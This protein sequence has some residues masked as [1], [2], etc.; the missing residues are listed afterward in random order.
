MR[1]LVLLG[2]ALVTF[3][4]PVFGQPKYGVT[5]TA[6]K[7]TDFTKF[8][9]YVWRTG[10]DA[11][12]KVHQQIVAAVDR[13]MKA[14]GYEKKAAGPSDVIVQYAAVRRIDVDVN[15]KA[16]GTDAARGQTDVGTLDIR[17]LKPGS[18]DQLWRARIDK[19]LETTDPAKVGEI[20]DG[21]VKELFA[22]YPTRMMKGK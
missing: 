14:L 22:Q 8:K 21:A 1:R 10:W 9:T 7:S 11:S 16:T 17:L 4:L 12:G 6:D 13:E 15:T 5:S 2:I 18:N 19:P 20:V 3:A